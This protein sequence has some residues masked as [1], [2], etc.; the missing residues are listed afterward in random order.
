MINGLFEPRI[1]LIFAKVKYQ[2]M[3]HRRKIIVEII[4]KFIFKSENKREFLKSEF[5]D[6]FLAGIYLS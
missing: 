5:T 2:E 3:I 6:L 4:C 1:A